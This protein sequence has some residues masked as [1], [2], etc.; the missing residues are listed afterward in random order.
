V[1]Q[2]FI[3]YSRNERPVAEQLAVLLT[4]EGYDVWWDA[5]LLSGAHFED[6][7]RKALNAAPAAIIL[8]SK[9]AIKSEWV[10]AEAEFARKQ[11]SAMPVIIDN[12]DREALPLLFQRLHIIEMRGWSGDPASKGYREL[13]RA[14]SAKLK[15]APG[16]SRSGHASAARAVGASLLSRASEWLAS[17]AVVVVVVA[18]AASAFV[19]FSQRTATVNQPIVGEASCTAPARLVD[20]GTVS[21]CLGSGWAEQPGAFP[22]ERDYSN[23]AAGVA[24]IVEQ[25][26]SSMAEVAAR[27]EERYFFPNGASVED[28][29]LQSIGGRTWTVHTLRF[30]PNFGKAAVFPVYQLR[31][32]GASITLT[33]SLGEAGQNPPDRDTILASVVFANA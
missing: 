17:I 15:Q 16:G 27:L 11:R 31:V 9:A 3:S 12:L 7:I 5:S 2:I 20:L 26:L 30:K 24:L 1:P 29:G 19:Y 23:T 21:F 4:A 13:L 28:N 6:E 22:G 18:L 14:V 8:W 33:F 32:G 25:R 10:S